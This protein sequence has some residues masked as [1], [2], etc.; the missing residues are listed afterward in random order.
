MPELEPL[1]VED[2]VREAGEGEGAGECAGREG[3]ALMGSEYGVSARGA[4]ACRHEG[5]S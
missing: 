1:A 2:V 3:S 5:S 4:V